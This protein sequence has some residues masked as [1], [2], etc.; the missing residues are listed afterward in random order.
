MKY[1]YNESRNKKKKEFNMRKKNSTPTMKDVALEAGVALGTVSKVINGLPVGESYRLR[2]EAAI[3]KLDYHVNSYAQ[4]LKASKTYTVALLIPN[5]SNPFFAQ[6]V[7]H[8]NTALLKRKYRMLLCTTDYDSSL[9]QEYITI[10]RQNKVDGII[11]LTYNPNLHIEEHI[12]FVS[13]DRPMGAHIPCVA[14]DNFAGGQMAVE[15]LADLGCKNIAFLRVGSSLDSEPNKR[16]AG[17]EN[18][19]LARELAYAIKI[20]QDGEPISE[21]ESFFKEHMSNGKLEFDGL[22][23]VTDYLAYEVRKILKKL[24]IRVPEDVQIIGFDGVRIFGDRDYVC[25]TIVQPVPDIA[26]MC[27][28]LLLQENMHTKPPL[29]CL[30]VSYAYGGTTKETVPS[31]EKGSDKP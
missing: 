15:K 26:E 13:I 19:C 31:E 17:F 29:I 4:G 1:M 18:G 5:T 3:K 22:F 12:P 27:V 25:S 8:I 9:E 7:Y 2:V 23:C 11:G 30:P 6:L 20:L 24:N 16:R 28:E 14:S 10:T 21:F